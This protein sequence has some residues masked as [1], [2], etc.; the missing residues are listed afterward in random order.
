MFRPNFKDVSPGWHEF[1]LGTIPWKVRCGGAGINLARFFGSHLEV[2]L[3]GQDQEVNLGGLNSGPPLVAGEDPRQIAFR[4]PVWLLNSNWDYCGEGLQEVAFAADGTVSIGVGLRILSG[5]GHEGLLQAGWKI[6]L[7]EGSQLVAAAGRLPA[8][9]ANKFEDVGDWVILKREQCFMGVYWGRDLKDW[10]DPLG[11][12][13]LWARIGDGRH[14]PFYHGWESHLRQWHGPQGWRA[15]PGAR[16]VL[17]GDGLLL[18]WHDRSAAKLAPEPAIHFSGAVAVVPGGSEEEVRR[19]ILALTA[20]LRPKADGAAVVGFDYL[21]GAYRFR[22]TRK[23]CVVSF[24]ADPLGRAAL[25]RVDGPPA[26]ALACKV[27]G[28]AARPQLVSVGR[29]DDPYGPNDGRPDGGARPVLAAA[30]KP[31]ERVE[32]AVT[33]SPERP[34]RIEVAEAEGLSLSYLS[35]DDRRELL[36]F[37]SRDPAAPLGRLSLH[38]LRLRDIRPPGMSRSAVACLPLYWY[39][40]NAPSP[41]H[42]ANRLESWELRENGPSAVRLQLVAANPG[43]S[44]LSTFDLGITLSPSGAL[45]FDI[46]AKLGIVGNFPVPHFQFCNL[47]PENTR[48]PEEWTHDETL[49]ATRSELRA[50]DNRNGRDALKR[51]AFTPPFFLAQ[52]P[53]RPRDPGAGGNLALLVTGCRPEGT[54]L[55]YELCRC[56]LDNHLYVV[57]REGGPEVGASYEVRYQV[58]A[59]PDRGEGRAG[60]G[61]LARAALLAGRLEV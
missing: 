20:P 1:R 39:L 6:T 7:G 4:V 43:E 31:A 30:E 37:S 19:R 49:A 29:T 13:G 45:L 2:E 52:Y 40:M 24:P 3:A 15:R 8:D 22:R 55:A 46:A 26:A 33:L 23:S 10:C 38:D 17:E 56:W 34:T 35:Q 18:A 59:W 11:G 32:L 25:A 21:E 61:K 12:E 27:D 28:K 54:P 14:P 16:L 60:I 44:V 48:L 51:M 53:T 57:F 41:W 36:L 58:A 42:S 9:G 50:V 47:F 5:S